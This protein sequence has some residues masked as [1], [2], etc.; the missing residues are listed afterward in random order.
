M[1]T[2][3]L[4]KLLN[5]AKENG[6]AKVEN[7]GYLAYKE[8]DKGEE[9]SFYFV[10][11][12]LPETVRIPPIPEQELFRTM[13]Q[14][15]ILKEIADS[16]CLVRGKDNLDPN[17]YSFLESDDSVYCKRAHVEESMFNS[18]KIYVSNDFNKKDNF[19]QE[20]LERTMNEIESYL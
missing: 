3:K 10:Y 6:K 1:E 18:Y 12:F 5:Q 16:Y 13:D 17:K 19:L 7:L 9:V 4:L 20:T 8:T 14:R 11:K 15:G 2:K